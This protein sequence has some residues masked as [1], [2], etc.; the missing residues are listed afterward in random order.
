MDAPFGTW[1]SPIS[2][3]TASSAIVAFQDLALDNDSIYWSE[4]RPSEGGRYVIVQYKEGVT[5]DILPTEFNARTR[6]HEYGGAAFAVYNSIIYFTNYQDQRLYR[7]APNEKPM[8]LTKAG[9]RFA[10]LQVTPYG[11]VAIAESHQSNEKEPQNYLALINTDTGEVTTLASGQDFYSSPAL[12]KDYSKI[13]WISWNHPNMPWDDTQLWVANISDKGLSNTHQIDA[14]TT[15][16]SFFEPQWGPENQLLVVSDKSNWWNLYQVQGE[17]LKPL[18]SVE[19]EIGQPL[20]T[21]GA[22]VW[23]FYQKGIVCAFFKDGQN[24]L[25]YYDGELHNLNIPYRNFSQIRTKDNKIAF[26]AGAPDKP[27]AVAFLENQQFT[28]VKENM[29]SVDPGYLSVPLHMTYPSKD[30]QS[31]AYYY[32]PKNKD[33]KGPK[34]QLPP[35]IVRS[36][37]GPTANCGSNLNLDIQYWTSR[38]FAFVD[39]NYAGSTGYGR[40]YRHSLN[41]QWGVYDVQDCVNVAQYLV[42]K[43]MVDKHKLAITGGSA[44]GYTTL[45][46]LT[47]SDTFAVGASHYGVSEL[48]AL[49][50]DTHKFESRYLDNLIGPYPQEKQRYHDRSPLYHI[51]KLNSPV[52]FFQGDEDKIVLPNQ[53]QMM[54]DA[55]I[56]KGIMS[57][58][59]LFKGEQHGF[60]KAENRITALEKQR[61]FFLK[62]FNN[63]KE[64]AK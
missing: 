12:N 31:H 50:Q 59:W 33:F 5:K 35:L 38:G 11:I 18:F 55:L 6:V 63:N 61:A 60:R 34:N 37:G 17:T 48:V 43:G 42:D 40:A 24:H 23:G 64:L 22:S 54:Y 3:Q 13:A 36:H 62:V 53:A 39:V 47:F 29:Q 8:P 26:F 41:Q 9:V 20:W 1:E 45:A 15:A 25:F 19:S 27:S 32:A 51:E 2:A 30:R 58:Y 10:D 14:K 4:M 7:L 49:V 44:G 16:Q 57:E 28:V 46:A 56:E 21:F 52:I